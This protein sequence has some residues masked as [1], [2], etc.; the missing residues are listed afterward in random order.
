MDKINRRFDHVYYLH[1]HFAV[2]S[3]FLIITGRDTDPQRFFFGPDR[4]NGCQYFF[5]KPDP[6]LQTATI[7]IRAPVGNRRQ[8]LMNKVAMRRMDL[9]SVES[10]GIDPP[11][12]RFEGCNNL[13]D[14]CLRQLFRHTVIAAKADSARGKRLSCG[15]RA[16]SAGVVDLKRNFGAVCM[17]GIHNPFQPGNL[18]VIPDAKVVVR[19]PAL[20]G[21]TGRLHNDQPYSSQSSGGIVA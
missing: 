3:T 18:V 15:G 17:A 9:Q 6:V 4:A 5:E 21:Y 16:L 14:L 8:K 10:G 20:R 11:S 7:L 1:H 13:T 2:D 12:R 19:E